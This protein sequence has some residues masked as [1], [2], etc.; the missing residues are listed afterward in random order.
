M[1]DA[2]EVEA[3]LAPVQEAAVNEELPTL[4]NPEEAEKLQLATDMARLQ[5]F[6]SK[7]FITA[8]PFRSTVMFKPAAPSK[9]DENGNVVQPTEEEKQ[10]VS[11][12]PLAEGLFLNLENLDEDDMETKEAAL[13]HAI[14]AVGLTPP[15]IAMQIIPMRDIKIEL[16]ESFDKNAKKL[17][18]TY[19]DPDP[20]NPQPPAA[21]IVSCCADIAD[22][23]SILPRGYGM[24]V[25]KKPGDDPNKKTPRPK[26]VVRVNS[27]YPVFI[28]F[29]AINLLMAERGELRLIPFPV[30]MEQYGK[31]KDNFEENQFTFCG[32]MA[33]PAEYTEWA[34]LL[35]EAVAQNG[36]E[37]GYATAARYGYAVIKKRI[38]DEY[39]DKCERIRQSNEKIKAN[40]EWRTQQNEI[41]CKDLTEEQIKT[42][43]LKQLEE[44]LPYPAKPDIENR[45]PADAE[46]DQWC[47]D[48]VLMHNSGISGILLTQWSDIE[49]LS[50]K[51]METQYQLYR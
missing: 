13:R 41:M 2:S 42:A 5:N 35:Q 10:N 16:Y 3:A 28:W 8:A 31:E 1:Q 38:L 49:F 18:Y 50:E 25:T 15:R 29:R 48:F 21:V 27:E 33:N 34:N 26:S 12:R 36:L 46:V 32:I 9:V 11:D 23:S 19:E 47:T 40:N 6:A 4:M 39:E 17:G 20:K 24:A 43:N 45:G 22:I 30:I 44:F 14:N 51:E 37:L 7:N